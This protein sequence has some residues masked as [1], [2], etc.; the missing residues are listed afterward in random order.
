MS[1]VNVQAVSQ[2]DQEQPSQVEKL[3][4]Y[5]RVNPILEH[6]TN[7]IKSPYSPAEWD[8]VECLDTGFVFLKNPP[9]YESLQEEYAWEK[10]VESY[11]QKSLEL[12]PVRAKLS[13]FF[14]KIRSSM[15]RGQ[16][17]VHEASQLLHDIQRYRADKSAPMTVIDVGCGE[18]LHGSMIAY[19]AL[20]Q[21]GINVKPIG[22]EVS[23]FLAAASN[24]KFK[25]YGGHVIHKPALE[26]LVELEDNSVDVIVLMSFLEHEIQPAELL[27]VC[28]QKLTDEGGIVLKVPNYNSWNRVIRKE[29]WC[30]FRFPDHVNYFSPRT[31]KVLLHKCGLRAARMNFLDTV[32]TNDNMWA[33]IKKK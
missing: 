20:Y 21:H 1:Q 28:R 14:K 31:L 26:G 24:K 15:H 9:S 22:I 32:P 10:S 11:R 2:G 5:S 4:S 18:G 7:T 30:G 13:S 29:K 17:V 19:Q 33:I 25:P 12:E 23:N 3:E 8:L 27:R 16:K 6:E